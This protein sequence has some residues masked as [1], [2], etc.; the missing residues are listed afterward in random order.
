MTDVNVDTLTMSSQP[1]AQ[2][3]DLNGQ[4]VTEPAGANTAQ[5]INQPVTEPSQSNNPFLTDEIQLT[6]QGT[7]YPKLKS[8]SLNTLTATKDNNT[9]TVNFNNGTLTDTGNT[10]TA[11]Q[12]SQLLSAIGRLMPTFYS[13]GDRDLDKL[14][15]IGRTRN[16]GERIGDSKT[17]QTL[18][19]GIG[20]AASSIGSAAS[21]IG[22][23]AMRSFLPEKK[24]D[25]HSNIDAQRGELY[26]IKYTP[27][28][29]NT[30]VNR[31]S[32]GAENLYDMLGGGYRSRNMRRTRGG[33]RRTQNKKKQYRRSKKYR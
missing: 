7:F 29:E 8:V 21:S 30:L 23:A 33:R 25:V 4:P 11:S 22:S 26:K 31:K 12:E 10:N 18:K 13:N 24:T 6:I 28:D 3:N 19:S 16:M 17:Y 9:A 32:Q 15:T 5:I 20:S 1:V 27:N 14:L 2:S